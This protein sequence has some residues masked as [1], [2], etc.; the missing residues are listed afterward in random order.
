M[1]KKVL[2]ALRLTLCVLLL[3]CIGVLTEKIVERSVEHQVRKFDNADINHMKY[4]LFSVNNWKKKLA[5]IVVS[6]IQNF[7][8]DESNKETLKKHL[9]A[10]LDVLIDKVNSQIRESNKDSTKG[11]FKQKLMDMLVDVKVIK[12]GIPEYADAIVKQMTE[13][14]TQLQVKD[15]LRQRVTKYLDQTFEKT[16]TAETDVIV[17]RTGATSIDRA[18]EILAATVPIENHELLKM[19]GVLIA[20]SVLLFLIAGYHHQT[21]MPAPYFFICLI[22]LLI[23][24]FAGVT[25]PMIDMEAKI[26]KFGFV[27]LGHNIEFK[28]MTVYFQSKSIIDVFWIMITHVKPEMKV[29]GVLMILFSIVF[30]ILKLISSLFYYYEVFGIQN[31]FLMRAIV[32]KSGK[33]SMADVQV[34]AILMAYI[35][36]NGMVTTQLG[37]LASTVPGMTFISMNGTTLQ[38]GFYIFLTYAVLAMFFS[39]MIG[40]QVRPK[41]QSKLKN[42]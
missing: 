26:S 33:W 42:L 8:I 34:V 35:G 40:R 5:R 11:W 21:K 18:K 9:E 1:F 37:V 10:Q 29:V 24:L 31:N 16:D 36:F 4:S 28:D 25:C 15:M 27:L 6:E 7:K 14:K 23:L 39:A 32:L 20:L 3:V 38:I 30:P 2:G 41:N 17:K 19:T 12:S 22:A 13:D